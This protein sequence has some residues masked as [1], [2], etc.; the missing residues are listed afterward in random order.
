MKTS[1]IKIIVLGASLVSILSHLSFGAVSAIRT[2]STA[3]PPIKAQ[4]PSA[5][6]KARGLPFNG[7]VAAVDKAAKTIT[8]TGK[9]QRIFH[10]TSETKI[11]KNQKPSRIEA[12]A[13]G[14]YVG[15]YAREAPDGKLELVTLNI[16]SQSSESK[17]GPATT[18]AR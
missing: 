5:G 11:N 8:M 7:N 1:G 3:I 14:D 13:V 4:P 10:F 6:K 16:H 12:L 18:P 9:K 2:N 15:G 17:S